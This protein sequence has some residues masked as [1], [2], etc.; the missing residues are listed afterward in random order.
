MDALGYSN[1]NALQV[2]YRQKPWH[3]LQFDANYTWSHTLGLATPNNWTSQSPQYTLRNLRGSYG[4]TLFDLRN[5]IH[6]NGTYDLPF[7]K[8]RRWLDHGGVANRIVGGWTLG[9][10]FTFQTGAPQS[11]PRRQ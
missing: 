3:G 9:D 2:D 8:G 7:G 10:I 4:P 6:A 11:D 1:Y 5:V